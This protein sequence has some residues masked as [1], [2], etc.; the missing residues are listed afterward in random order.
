MY[1]NMKTHK[2]AFPCAFCL[3]SQVTSQGHIP[4]QGVWL[5]VMCLGPILQMYF[6]FQDVSSRQLSLFSH[7]AGLRHCVV[8]Q[9][10]HLLAVVKS[11]V[12]TLVHTCLVT[13]D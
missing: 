8:V 4:S 7:T 3:D 12:C 2:H 13:L 6:A 5:C 11:A 10:V 9:R 1:I